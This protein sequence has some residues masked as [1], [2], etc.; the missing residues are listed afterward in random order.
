[1][2]RGEN[3]SHQRNMVKR[4]MIELGKYLIEHEL[5][6]GNSGNMSARVENNSMLMT[7]SGTQMG[8]LAE[9]DLVE[10]DIETKEWTGDRKPSK[11]IPMHEM[12]YKNRADAQVI[13][14]SSPFWSTLIACSDIPV[15]S[16]LFVESMYY[17]ENVAYVDYFHPGT[18]ELGE[19]VGEKA[20]EA[21]V[22]FL[23]NHGIIVFDDSFKEASMR[24]ETLELTCRMLVTAK[25]HGINLNRLN[26]ETVTDFLESSRY[27]PRKKL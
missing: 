8:A 26:D 14:H 25:S 6:W 15:L 23:K 1:M 5:A 13:I 9:N 21:N 16:E 18:K 11:E 20:K 3:M 2:K 17:L 10:V 27:K 12:I 4:N 19:A 7:G 22:L 24:I